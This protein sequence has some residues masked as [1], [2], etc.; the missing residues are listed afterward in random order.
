MPERLCQISPHDMIS[1]SFHPTQAS[2]LFDSNKDIQ[3][4]WYLRLKQTNFV[5][6]IVV[7]NFAVSIFRVRGFFPATT[8]SFDLRMFRVTSYLPEQIK[9]VIRGITV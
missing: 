2:Y 5:L 3:G 4:Q 7:S 9:F 1:C 6:Q 8:V